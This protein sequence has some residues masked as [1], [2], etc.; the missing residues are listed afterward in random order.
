MLVRFDRI[1]S[2][3]SIVKYPCRNSLLHDSS[4]VDMRRG[5]AATRNAI[6]TSTGTAKA[7]GKIL[8]ELKGVVDG[9]ALRIPM[10]V[11][12]F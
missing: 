1:D 6:H 10:Q 4:K 5:W 9:T 7:V 12:Q 8:P 11:R 2:P 3:F